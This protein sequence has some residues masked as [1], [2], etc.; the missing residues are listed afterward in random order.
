[1]LLSLLAGAVFT[2]NNFVVNQLDISVVDAVLLRWLL[3]LPASAAL[4][5]WRGESLTGSDWRTTALAATQVIVLSVSCKNVAVGRGWRHHRGGWTA[6]CG[7]H[8]GAG[9]AVCYLLLPGA[10][11]AALRLAAGGAAHPTADWG[12]N[13]PTGWRPP[14]MQG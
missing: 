5:W 2:A 7:L 8:A 11:A 6:Q 4:L 14:R 12:S 1:M 3:Q 13:T 10:G 9:R